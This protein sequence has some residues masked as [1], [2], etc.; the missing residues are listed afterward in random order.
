MSDACPFDHVMQMDGIFAL[1]AAAAD[2]ADCRGLQLNTDRRQTTYH[3]LTRPPCGGGG[4]APAA[5]HALGS[6]R[7][8]GLREVWHRHVRETSEMLPCGGSASRAAF[9]AHLR[10][11]SQRALRAHP[12]KPPWHP[13]QQLREEGPQSV[14]AVAGWTF[15]AEHCA[16]L[17]FP[18]RMAITWLRSATS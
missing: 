18:L 6:R 13:C 11:A 8:S 16:R 7:R 12:G 4:A 10:R 9:S 1:Y 15:D 3:R 17:I 14:S 2:L 5:Q